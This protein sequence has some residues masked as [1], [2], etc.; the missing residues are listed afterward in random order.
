MDFPSRAQ[1]PTMNP[2]QQHRPWLSRWPKA[3]GAPAQAG[4]MGAPGL[5]PEP[6]LAQ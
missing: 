3:L 1:H 2:R 4:A 6:E 5:A